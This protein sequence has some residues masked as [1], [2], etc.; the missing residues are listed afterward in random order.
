L[1]SAN[2]VDYAYRVV[3]PRTYD[4][5]VP[6]ALVVNW[7]ALTSSPAET[8]ALTH[9]DQAGEEANVVM[10]YPQ[11]PDKSWDVGTCCT[12]IEGGK[13]RDE[14]VFVRELLADV[15]LKLCIDSK[16]IYAS[17][18]SNGAMLSHMLACRMSDVFAAVVPMSGTL[19]IPEADCK[20]TRPI[21]IL[22]INGTEDPLVGYN[23]S[24]LSGGLPVR[25]AFAFWAHENQCTGAPEPSFIHGDASCQ[26]YTHCKAGAA[27]T[28]CTI[29]GMGHCIAGMKVESA[30]N[31]LTKVAFGLIPI[32]LG[33]PNDDIDAIDMSFHF[34]ERR[35]LP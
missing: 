33:P 27:V 10:V 22:M 14:V 2:G 31:C 25:D 15:Q 16:R 18:F 21:P 5:R 28:L 32:Q 24:S 29:K 20:P 13:R 35:I 11:S 30:S 7:H 19:T 9:I 1:A 23:A 8:R 34:F 4:P 12:E 3:V 6:A 17:G 26:T